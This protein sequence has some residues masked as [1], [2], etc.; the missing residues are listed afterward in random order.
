MNRQRRRALRPALELLDDR[1]LLSGLTPAQVTNAYGLNAITFSANGQTIPGN[2]SGQTIAIIDAYHDP[3]LTSDLNTFDQ[4]NHLPAA[5][6]AQ[7]DLAG[8]RADSG[9]AE[10]E[11]LD[12]E[13][14]HAIAPGA[15]I[16][17]VEARS[18]SLQDLLTAVNVAKQVPGVSV[19]S[20]SWGGSEFPGQTRYDGVF[21]TPAGHTGI[22]YVAASGD[23]GASGGAA[24]PASS[25]DVLAVGGTTLSVAPDGTYL[26]ESV[27]SGSGGGN[28]FLEAEPAYQRGVQSTSTR[29]TPDVSFVG[30]P[31][32]GVAVYTTDPATGLGSWFQ[33]GG[34]SVGA[35]AWA[36]IVAIADEGRALA[37]KGTLDSAT[38]TL[39]ALYS[40]PSS[41]FQQVSA[42]TSFGFGSLAGAA[43]ALG[44]P[45][46]AALVNGLVAYGSSPTNTST[47]TTAQS[48]VTVPTTSGTSSPVQ[49]PT[50][51]SG[52]SGN[53]GSGHSPV[54]VRKPPTTKAGGRRA[55]ASTG[56]ALPR[57]TW[58]L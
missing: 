48:A 23:Q 7:V 44:S 50:P 53:R 38:Q 52:G 13:W 9:W 15:T 31:N 35:P 45:K 22:T 3:Y 51:V 30:D 57:G 43:P 37:G 49:T 54:T 14:A 1:C 18:T 8:S 10:E 47:A 39:S 32:T 28:S 20:M 2:G 56:S 6:V 17:V 27:W 55:I 58:I 24:W 21:T 16:V 33:V 11:T 19:V 29:T 26:G 41:D 42:S 4:A 25:P 36:A 5:A 46:G 34:T 12:T 40:L